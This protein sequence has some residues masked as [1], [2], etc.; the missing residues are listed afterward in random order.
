MQRE[1]TT[2]ADV[3]QAYRRLL[4]DEI[5]PALRAL[6]LSGS[7][8][9]FHFDS[10]DAWGLLGFR[11]SPRRVDGAIWFTVDL[12]VVSKLVWDSAQRT[13]AVPREHPV[14]GAYNGSFVWD[15]PIGRLMPEP[16]DR[17]WRVSIDSDL[18]SLAADVVAAIRDF[19]LPAARTHL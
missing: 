9:V 11:A 13:L 17:W 18:G 10:D 1:G 5:A 16:A 15:R 7:G 8:R 3:A 14:P 6:G 2:V 19:G 4:R 12:C